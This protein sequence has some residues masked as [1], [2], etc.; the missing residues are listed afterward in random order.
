[1]KT[2]QTRQS[3][4]LAMLVA[5]L[6]VLGGVAAPVEESHGPDFTVTKVRLR[7]K[8]SW[9]VRGCR[10]S[11][12]DVGPDRGFRTLRQVNFLKPDKDWWFTITVKNAEPHR[13]VRVEGI[14]GMM[15]AVTEVEFHSPAGKL[16]GAAFGSQV[17]GVKE[18]WELAFDGDP[19]TACAATARHGYAGLDLGPQSQATMRIEPSAGVYADPVDI[20]ISHTP[21]SGTVRYTLDGSM[22]SREHGEIYTGP[23]RLET[24]GVVTAVAF[25]EGLA[26]T[27]IVTRAYA[28]VGEAAT[29]PPVTSLHLGDEFS[30]DATSRLPQ[31]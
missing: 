24:A 19:E 10:I 20:K 25:D 27:P 9:R 28:V 29:R 26:A 31:V 23:V 15:D 21:A 17:E 2:L 5:V 8:D 1:M 11:G 3:N 6:I 22:P 30:E 7:L 4:M 16:A 14:T 18:P 12:S 13:W